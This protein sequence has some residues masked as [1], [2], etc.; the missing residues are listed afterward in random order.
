M[1]VDDSTPQVTN[2]SFAAAQEDP[3]EMLSRVE[4]YI[5]N[6]ESSLSRNACQRFSQLL[7][8]V[9]KPG[10]VPRGLTQANR[11]QLQLS[12]VAPFKVADDQVP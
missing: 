11:K 7:R 1:I 9:L 12:S 8:A 2:L 4:G 3:V 5:G 6:Q 10:G